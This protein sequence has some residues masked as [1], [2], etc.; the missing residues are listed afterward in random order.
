MNSRAFTKMLGLNPKLLVHDYY[1]GVV[2]SSRLDE[3]YR[4]MLKYYFGFDPKPGDVVF[5]VL[6]RHPAKKVRSKESRK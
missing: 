1:G 6:L 2:D 4:K 3:K 5:T